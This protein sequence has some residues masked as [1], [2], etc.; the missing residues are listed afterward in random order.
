[1]ISRVNRDCGMRIWQLGKIAIN[2]SS[3]QYYI[4]Y[5]E[6]CR[7]KVW[8]LFTKGEASDVY[9]AKNPLIGTLFRLN[10]PEIC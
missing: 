3:Y 10:Y 7:R 6:N 9:I 2:S 1:M 4:E 8:K 5:G